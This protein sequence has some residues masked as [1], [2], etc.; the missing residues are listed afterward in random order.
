MVIASPIEPEKQPSEPESE[1]A[2][3]SKSSHQDDDSE[4]KNELYFRRKLIKSLTKLLEFTSSDGSEGGGDTSAQSTKK[5]VSSSDA[6]GAAPLQQDGEVDTSERDPSSGQT[7]Q[8]E[9]DRDDMEFLATLLSRA[10][11]QTAATLQHVLDSHPDLET[12]E[13]TPEG[14][15]QVLSHSTTDQSPSSDGSSLLSQQ[16]PSDAPHGE[17]DRTQG[18]GHSVPVEMHPEEGSGNRD[19][20]KKKRFVEV[21]EKHSRVSRVQSRV[22]TIWPSVPRSKVDIEQDSSRDSTSPMKEEKTIMEEGSRKEED[23]REVAKKVETALREHL[24]QAGLDPQGMTACV[25]VSIHSHI[26]RDMQSLPCI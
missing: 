21:S 12:V 25:G 26:C 6:G 9:E 23:L 24:D 17:A 7:E 10:V 14:H 18:D 1:V 13:K 2:E 16:D 4:E 19:L 3:P 11:D 8:Q 15:S 20:G 5:A 22:R